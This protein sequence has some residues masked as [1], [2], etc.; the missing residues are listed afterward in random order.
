ME[1]ASK[2]G[3]L[4][5]MSGWQASFINRVM[6]VLRAGDE[7]SWRAG[8][9][10]SRIFSAILTVGGMTILVKLVSTAKEVVVAHQFGVGDGLDAFLIAFLLPSVAINIIAG[11][12]NAGLMPTYIQIRDQQGREAAQRLFSSVMIC[13]GLLLIIVSLLMALAAPRALGSLGSGFGPEKLALTRKLFYVLLPILP[14]SGMFVTWSAVLN[15]SGRF[16][17]AAISPMMTPLLA[18]IVVR[19]FSGSSGIYSLAVAMVGGV[20][21]EGTILAA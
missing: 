15:A 11:S 21:L 10:N 18:I 6:P 8:S 17:L 9:A 5:S 19:E 16:A 20:I 7:D 14:L 12:F 2:A 4:A 1:D 13:S 3:T